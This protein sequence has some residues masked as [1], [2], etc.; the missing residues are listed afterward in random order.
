MAYGA[1][2]PRP[3]PSEPLVVPPRTHGGPFATRSAGD[4]VEYQEEQPGREPEGGAQPVAGA[5]RV[6]R[7][8]AKKQEKHDDARAKPQPYHRPTSFT[9]PGALWQVKPLPDR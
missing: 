1:G 9:E 3:A 4:A 2:C 8:H 6:E 7:S 5:Y